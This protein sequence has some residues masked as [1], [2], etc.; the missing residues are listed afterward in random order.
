MAEAHTLGKGQWLPHSEE[1][2]SR[3]PEP[4]AGTRV[5]VSNRP[6]PPGH[7]TPQKSQAGAET[8][9]AAD[10]QC[11]LLADL[12]SAGSRSKPSAGLSGP[13]A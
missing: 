10:L 4:G 5:Q 3:V 2:T 8:G 13:K 9:S 12:L 11:H 1:G 6:S 7:E